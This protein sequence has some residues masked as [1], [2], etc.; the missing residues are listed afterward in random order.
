MRS[1]GGGNR[2]GAQ[3]RRSFL[4]RALQTVP[5]QIAATRWRV[6]AEV[7]RSLLESETAA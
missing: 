1:T 6:L 7:M 4:G 2:P 3:A 5:T